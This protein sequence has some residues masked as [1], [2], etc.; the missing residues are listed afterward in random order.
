MHHKYVAQGLTVVSVSLDEDADKP[1]VQEK[2]LQF[3]KDK[4]AA[5]ANLILDEPFE[6]WNKKLDFVSPPCVFVFD[7][8]GRWRKF[9]AEALAGENGEGDA[10]LEKLIVELLKQQ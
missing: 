4:K 8:Q 1:E 3:L 10:K 6:V 2:A 9:D 7:R 5:F